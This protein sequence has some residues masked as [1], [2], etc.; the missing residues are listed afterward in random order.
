V[1]CPEAL[2]IPWLWS[3]ISK[4][5][6]AS[7]GTASAWTCYRTGTL[8]ATGRICSTRSDAAARSRWWRWRR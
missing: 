1:L 5:V 6:C 3:A 2:I 8:R 4:P 7:T